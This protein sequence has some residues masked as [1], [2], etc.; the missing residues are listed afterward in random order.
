MRRRRE[1][2]T[3][4][5]VAYPGTGQT[6]GFVHGAGEGQIVVFAELVGEGQ[7]GKLEIGLIDDQQRI[8][9]VQNL[10]HQ[11]PVQDNLSRRVVGIVDDNQARLAQLLEQWRGWQ[12]EGRAVQAD[13]HQL[14]G[15]TPGHLH[16]GRKGR[17]DHHHF[18]AASEAQ[19]DLPKQQV[20]TGTD[21]DP[22]AVDPGILGQKQRQPI[23]GLRVGV[24]VQAR[25]APLGS[26]DNIL[27]GTVRHLVEIELDAFAHNRTSPCRASFC[28]SAPGC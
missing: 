27:R 6:K 5:Q 23:Q 17:A 11:V 13:A 20:R 10:L 3:R 19:H 14:P 1:S 26:S 24:A 28:V 4:D 8:G 2:L 16:C 7:T 9:N 22:F 15:E 12:R 25:Q 21:H 18:S